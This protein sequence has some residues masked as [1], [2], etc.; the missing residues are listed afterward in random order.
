MFRM[1]L[2]PP[3]D[4]RIGA[5]GREATALK[6]RGDFESAIVVLKML[7]SEFGVVSTRLPKYL[8]QAGRETE[9]MAEFAWMID[10][11]RQRT[12][13]VEGNMSEPERAAKHL[14]VVHWELV[15]INNAM[16][17]ELDRKKRHAEAAVHLAH[18]EGNT[19]LARHHSDR[20]ME[21]TRERLA[22]FATGR[23][24]QSIKPV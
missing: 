8:M 15:T 11:V 21:L 19:A 10:T 12:P 17:V 20:A 1:A 13:F 9:A 18:V 22:A 7:K 16:R 4:P 5:L 6:R 3:P 2:P 14:A 24:H 23:R